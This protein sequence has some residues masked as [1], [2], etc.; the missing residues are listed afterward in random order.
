[1]TWVAW[2]QQRTVLLLAL[3]LVALVAAALVALRVAATGAA[4]DL[5][6][7]DCLAAAGTCPDEALA[8]FDE[9]FTPVVR[10]LPL[11]LLAL[12]VLLGTFAGAPLFAREYEQGTH[13]FGLAQGVSRRRWWAAKVVVSG[14]PLVSAVL[15]LGL[16]TTWAL[17]SLGP[18]AYGRLTLPGFETQGLVVGGYFLFAF[19]VAATAGLVL[20]TTLGAIAVTLIAYVAVL[21]VLGNA[22]RPHYLPAERITVPITAGSIDPTLSPGRLPDD[23]WV[24]RTAYV[25]ADGTLVTDVSYSCTTHADIGECLVAQGVAAESV[26]YHPPSRFWTF[27]GIES[28]L[29]ATLAGAVLA[30]GARRLRQRAT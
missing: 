16:L 1:V 9:R 17:Q 2:R 14:L 18:V 11:A 29:A 30:L 3:S 20:R 27:Q 7:T 15:G 5:G 12:P 21:V 4:A 19:A 6:L 22:A 28:A 13:L 8:D 26:E 10:L 23:A 25:R 24:E